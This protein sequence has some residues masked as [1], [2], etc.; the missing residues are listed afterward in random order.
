MWMQN[1]VL[2]QQEV[3]M[4]SCAALSF[5]QHIQDL[6][7]QHAGSPNSTSE[8]SLLD[9]GEHQDS[10]PGEGYDPR[11]VDVLEDLVHVF[12]TSVNRAP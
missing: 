12:F 5:L 8:I 3:Y 1:I 10:D 6:F 9:E 11:D 4:G 2:M 7:T